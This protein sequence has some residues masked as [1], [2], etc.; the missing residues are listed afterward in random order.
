[1]P[2]P[3]TTPPDDQL[4]DAYSQAVIGAV[5]LLAPAVV[6]VDVHHRGET[7]RRPTQDD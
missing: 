3:L 2:T 6:S 5:E 4:F 7:G 1:M